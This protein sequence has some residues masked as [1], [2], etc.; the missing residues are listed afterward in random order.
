MYKIIDSPELAK[1]LGFG[2]FYQ[3]LLAYYDDVECDSPTIKY[4]PGPYCASLYVNIRNDIIFH[5][6]FDLL[7]KN[8]LMIRAE[9]GAGYTD[10]K[11]IEPYLEICYEP[12]DVA[13]PDSSIHGQKNK[14]SK[15]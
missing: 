14:D 15:E 3:E 10:P 1:S 8:W 9:H 13:D 7:P 11:I 4:H 5:R 12:A 6:S 2:N